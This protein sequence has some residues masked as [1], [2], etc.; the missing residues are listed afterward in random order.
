MFDTNN[1]YWTVY[2][3]MIQLGLTKLE[4]DR[5]IEFPS[6]TPPLTVEVNLNNNKYIFKC[7]NGG[8]ESERGLPHE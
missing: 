1:F 6:G 7:E 2:A 3:V 5:P 8:Q 4:L